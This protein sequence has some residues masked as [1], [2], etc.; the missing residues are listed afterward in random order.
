MILKI[1]LKHIVFIMMCF[2]VTTQSCTEKN[3]STS[4]DEHSRISG[5]LIADTII[6]SVEIKNYNPH[7]QWKEECLSHL[8]RKR[9][10]DQLFKSVYKHGAQAYNYITEAPMTID[11]VRAIE[12]QEDFSRDKVSKLQF[13]ESWYYDE[14]SQQMNKQIHSILVA[15]EVIN[16]EGTLMG[17][18]AA[19]YIKLNHKSN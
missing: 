7:D 3:K 9:L 11:E 4:V 15:Y 19:F 13:W 18:K 12:E 17:H 2:I 5:T 10:V 16:D 14:K 1:K 6:Y 8:N